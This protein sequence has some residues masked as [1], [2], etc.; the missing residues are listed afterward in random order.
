M[1]AR[2]QPRPG[3]GGPFGRDLEVSFGIRNLFNGPYMN[4]GN[5]ETSAFVGKGRNIYLGVG[6]RF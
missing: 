4:A 1:D 2:W 6:T 3:A 5:V